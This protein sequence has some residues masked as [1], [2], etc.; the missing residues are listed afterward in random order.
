MAETI[1]PNIAYT[2]RDF[3]SLSADMFEYAR[4]VLPEWKTRDPNDFG[5]ILVELFAG[6]GDLLNYYID[7]VASEAYI[8]TAVL[9]RNLLALAR[10]LGYNP[11][12]QQAATA[13]L[14]LNNSLPNPIIIPAQTRLFATSVVDGLPYN[15]YFETDT[16]V[17][18][19][20]GSLGSAGMAT[21]TATQGVTVSQ[22]SLGSSNGTISQVFSLFQPNVAAAST[23]VEV[24][25]TGVWAPWR[26]VD[27]V[28]DFGP[29]DP[30]CQVFED[31]D[32]VSYVQFGDNVSGRVPTLGSLIRVTY[33]VCDGALGNVAA[34][35]ISGSVAPIAGLSAVT[36]TGPAVGGA[37]RESADSIR[38]NAPRALRAINR[39]VTTSDYS[40][41]ALQ[42]SGC[43]KASA[44]LTAPGNI[45]VYIAGT[46]ST[47]PSATL[48][49]A[50]ASYLADKTMAGT[51]VTIGDPVFAPLDV[52]ATVFVM[53]QYR[54]DYVRTNVTL[55]IQQALDYDQVAFGANVVPADILRAIESV[56]GVQTATLQVLDRAGYNGIGGVALN[57]NEIPVLGTL[58]LALQN[59]IA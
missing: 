51:T 50:V 35:S 49:A 32:G 34:A 1:P 11:T 45:T 18:V 10:M 46:S 58:G 30:V 13:T 29:T 7:R 8:E 2:S 22:E 56:D 17:T 47:L 14:Q 42:V 39:G 44:T 41:L 5:V 40:S 54:Q 52:T 15:I 36:N 38:Y 43:T 20:G 55:A 9:R 6:M 31:E 4:A 57:P 28:I 33:R 27:H 25:E 16:D 21:V 48:K 59:G 24:N 26:T 23:F 37:D 12:P 19:P 3:A 53:P